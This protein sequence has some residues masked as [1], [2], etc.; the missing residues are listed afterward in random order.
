MHAKALA[1]IDKDS[2]NLAGTDY[3]YV[4]SMQV[5]TCQAIKGE[6]KLPGAVVGLVQSFA[7]AGLSGRDPLHFTTLHYIFTSARSVLYPILYCLGV[8]PV[9]FLKTTMK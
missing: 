8:I 9:Y 5:K 4:L 7:T 1:D 3:A 2:A 6:F